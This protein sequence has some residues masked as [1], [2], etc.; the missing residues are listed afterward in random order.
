MYSGGG[1]GIPL[2]TFGLLGGCCLGVEPLVYA[3]LHLPNM[4]CI[5]IGQV[6]PK[7]LTL[8]INSVLQEMSHYHWQLRWEEGMGG[9]RWEVG[10]GDGWRR[11]EW[12]LR[13]EIFAT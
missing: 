2:S 5:F 11:W 12:E 1:G 3:I 10:G 13:G 9:G 7:T 8:H 6:F 4:Q